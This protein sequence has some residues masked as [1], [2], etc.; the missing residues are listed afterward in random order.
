M[1]RRAEK[2]RT[3]ALVTTPEEYALL[4][5]DEVRRAVE[6]HRGRDPLEVALDRRVPHARTVATQ[7]KY[8]ARAARKLPTFAAAGCILPP[9]AFE[10]ASSAACA[11]HKPLAG[12]TVLDLTRGQG[13]R[14]STR[15]NSSH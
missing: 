15:L 5:T 6:Q 10:Q 14:T 2:K 9:R 11:L 3:F 4:L 1:V 13:D 8:L 12:D 7:L